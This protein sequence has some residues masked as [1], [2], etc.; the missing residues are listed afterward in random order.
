[1]AV[2]EKELIDMLGL[3]DGRSERA[4]RIA[5]WRFLKR[6]DI[7]ALPGRVF[8]LHRIQEACRQS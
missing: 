7:R 1:M 8:S 4:Q 3:N 5:A 6:F 2:T